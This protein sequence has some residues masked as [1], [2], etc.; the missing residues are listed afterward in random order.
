MN[1]FYGV[2]GPASKP[3]FGIPNLLRLL[4]WHWAINYILDIIGPSM[5]F[6]IKMGYVSL[7]AYLLLFDNICRGLRMPR[8]M[9]HGYRIHVKWTAKLSTLFF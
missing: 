9:T 4:A 7:L 2:F 3:L 8:R 1:S 5:S 6:V